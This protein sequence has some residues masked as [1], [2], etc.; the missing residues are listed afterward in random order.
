MTLT[1]QTQT[2]PKADNV[3]HITDNDAK[4]KQSGKSTT[5]TNNT[6][7]LDVGTGNMVSSCMEKD[8][9]TTKSL[10]N[11]FLQIEKEH[12][13][14][15][16]MSQIQHVEID[17]VVYILSDDAYHFG[18]MFGSEINR[19]MAKGMIS[20]KNIDSAEILAIMVRELIGTSQNKDKCVYSIPANP[21][22]DDMNIIYHESVFKRI[23]ASLG[24]TP[25]S[26]N[27]AAAIVFSECEK[28]NFSGLAISFGAGM[29]NVAICYKSMPVIKFS[30]A[31]G[32]DW[33][34]INTA[35]SVGSIPNR[36]NAIKEK[37]TFDL[38]QFST[39]KKKEKQIKEALI[40]YYNNLISYTL[41]N[42][43]SELEQTDA[44]LPEKLPL[45]ISGGTSKVNGFIEIVKQQLENVE[46]P[47]EISEI[48]SAQNPLTSVAQGC[49]IYGLK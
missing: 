47:F 14:N 28:E 22:D 10:R 7:G 49:L 23:I 40:Y 27:E 25:I 46:F 36:V 41:K 39:G 38:V 19:P 30:I 6:F 42:I 3:E 18:N 11:V 9:I 44:Q 13:N 35:N 29:T 8:I 15:T 45:I 31:R 4:I 26:I 17:D 1:K 43:V 16:D 33:I 12:I 21:I 24:F 32:G 48:K 37:D 20:N 2:I 5:K 34:D